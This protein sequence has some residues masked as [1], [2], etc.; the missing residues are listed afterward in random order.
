M[1][2]E[3]CVYH[4]ILWRRSPE[5]EV[6]EYELQTVT[7]GVSAASF[8]V[9]RCLRQLDLDEDAKFPLA[10]SLLIHNTYVD[11]IITG[12]DSTGELLS[13]QQD[14]INLLQRGQFELKK[15]ASNCDALLNCIPVDD[16]AIESTLTPTDDAAL[17]VL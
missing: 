16:R 1:R 8:L 3:D 15:W 14:L 17:K 9:L 10:K 12:A 5:E 2:T 13:I 6:L 7:Y 11:D 4:H